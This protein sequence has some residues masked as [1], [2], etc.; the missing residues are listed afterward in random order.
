MNQALQ[1]IRKIYVKEGI[2][3]H[4]DFCI[5][6]GTTSNY[7]LNETLEMDKF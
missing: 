4:N 2:N 5:A 6:L 1:K 3:L 7:V